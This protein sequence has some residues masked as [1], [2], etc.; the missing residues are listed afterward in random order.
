M[1]RKIFSYHENDFKKVWRHTHEHVD[2]TEKIVIQGSHPIVVGNAGEE[3]HEN[4]LTVTLATIARL[5]V[6]PSFVLCA[7]LHDDNGWSPATRDSL[8]GILRART[9]PQR[10]EL[11]VMSSINHSSIL[12]LRSGTNGV[13]AHWH[14]VTETRIG[15]EKADTD[16]RRTSFLSSSGDHSV[17][18]YKQKFS[19]VGVR[20]SG[21]RV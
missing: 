5:L 3:V 9:L 15:V 7:T 18:D 12:S 19:F 4:Q 8:R 6:C 11:T 1:R 21:Y 16:V 20:R 13:V 2:F 14:W 10:I 17:C